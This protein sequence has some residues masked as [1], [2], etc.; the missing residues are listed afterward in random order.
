M[1]NRGL[2]RWEIIAILIY[3]VIYL[4]DEF[5]RGRKGRI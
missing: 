3:A 5:L 4:L 2:D 1:K